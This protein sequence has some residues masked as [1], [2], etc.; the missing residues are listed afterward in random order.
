[1]IYKQNKYILMNTKIVILIIFCLI[2]VNIGCELN[3]NNLEIPEP[4]NNAIKILFIGNSLTYSNNMPKIF[5]EL[6][7]NSGKEV[8]VDQI[9]PG[10][11]SLGFHST[12]AETINKINEQKWDYVI[13]QSSD[14]AAFYD[15]YDHEIRII[16]KLKNHI[17]KNNNETKIIYMMVS[18]L[19]D[20]WTGR[21][22][23]GE[24]VHYTY[25]QYMKMIYDGT[26]YIADQCDVIIAPVGI[27]WEKVIDEKPEMK[28]KLFDTDG[29][30]PALYGSYI[31]ACTY[32]CTIFSEE[33]NKTIQSID[34][35]DNIQIFF[36]L[37]VNL[38]I[39]NNLESCFA[40]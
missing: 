21:E 14:I 19:R 30:H 20:G 15:L 7:L 39:L 2:I 28:I 18:G 34:I 1:M 37:I 12:N 27:A 22:L 6:S 35:P 24:I 29:A 9:T 10:G 31:I 38:V 5:E 17:K 33:L 23:N 8:Y 11:V 13:L 36:Q 26:I 32:F 16:N 40:R 4:V 3:S 25:K